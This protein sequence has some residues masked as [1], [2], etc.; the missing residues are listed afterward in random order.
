MIYCSYNP[1]ITFVSNHLDHIAKGVNTY[2]IKYEKVLTLLL[3][4]LICQLFAINIK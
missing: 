2:S 4:E 3:E 1:N